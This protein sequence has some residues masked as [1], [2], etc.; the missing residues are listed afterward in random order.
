MVT[1]D[2]VAAVANFVDFQLSWGTAAGGRGVFNTAPAEDGSV[3]ISGV[4]V[5]YGSGK[6]VH[7]SRKQR[8]RVLQ[9]L[10]P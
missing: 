7:S 4:M 10:R 6:T 1:D 3:Q 8:K 9:T 5:E 2:A